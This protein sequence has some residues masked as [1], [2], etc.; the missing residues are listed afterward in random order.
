[1]L[2]PARL[3][4]AL[5]AALA[6]P[7]SIPAQS[8]APAQ[9]AAVR[10]ETGIIRE[11]FDNSVRP[12]D[13]F[14]RHV[15][16]GW[17]S[18]AKI[19]DDRA[20]VGSFADL[21]EESQQQLR[22][23]IEAAMNAT[24]AAPGSERRKI[25]DL[26]ASY[27]DT[28]RIE[29]AGI[30]P[31]KEELDRIAAIRSHADLPSQFARLWWLGAGNPISIGVGQDPKDA[32]RY[33]V[34]MGQSGLGLP[35]R[36]Y[37]LRE[38]ARFDE[39]RAAY[40]KYAETLL[41]LAGDSDPAAGA[42]AVMA[43]ERGLAERHW[44]PARNRDREA[45]YNPRTIAEL[46]TAAPTLAWPR[47]LADIGLA[48]SP[49]FIVR[50]PDYL[51]ALD[52]IIAQTPVETWKRYMTVNL[53]DSYGDRL[54]SDF[55]RA[56]FA[57]RGRELQ[58]I[59]EDRE[60]WKKAVAF[61][62]AT[63]GEAVGKLYVERHFPPE[64]KGRME[65]LV[66]NLR[67]AFRTGI[68]EL[69][70]MTP[71]TR[72]RAQEK[73]AK[74]NVK[75]GY[76]DQWRDYTSLEVTRDNLI[77][78][79]IARNRYL[80]QRSIDRI[81]SPIARHE[82]SMTPQTVNAYYNSSLNEIVFPAAI[83]QPPF[84]SM[85]A[86]DA[87]NYGGIGGVIGHEFSHGFDDQGSRSDGD[88]NLRDWWSES[89]A[90]AFRDRTA[91]L[92]AQYEALSPLPG[93]NVNGRLTLGENIGDLSGLAVAYKAYK[94]SLGGREAPVIDGLT[95]DQ[96][97]FIGWAQVWRGLYREDALRRRVLTD[98][99]SPNEYRTNQVLRNFD[100]FHAAFN[101]KPGDGMWLEPEKRVKIW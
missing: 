6:L 50:Q 57:F 43:L 38:G 16:G 44:E 15:N 96:R 20:T 51:A 52:A 10:S 46:E 22:A 81:G 98:S 60:R 25:G 53:L 5:A 14:F 11:N 13:D 79:E 12:Q 41:R 73:L 92:V 61:V 35:N 100:A 64:A 72:A 86:D 76:P 39:Q 4:L 71:E 78:N 82:W 26:Y 88:G 91:V 28:A 97:F 58:G 69:E 66:S 80:R 33:V 42:Q 49:A 74:F 85:Q 68:D 40:L 2:T 1:M 47:L 9:S 65:Q 29:A 90:K 63:M 55:Q 30:T 23:I 19:P 21:G 62:N 32:T 101:T 34:S 75:I 18:R 94:R 45:T 24:D 99:H 56:R 89:D 37:Y 31:L 8:D 17:L 59:E 54:S 7:I 36:E 93:L 70:W 87:L 48:A 84:F 3:R 83:L 77:A 27:M 95:G 67:E